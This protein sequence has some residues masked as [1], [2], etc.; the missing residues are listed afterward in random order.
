T[1]IVDMF[2]LVDIT[3]PD[4]SQLYIWVT[5][6]DGTDVVLSAYSCSGA[7][8][9]GTIF[10]DYADEYIYWGTAP[11]TGYFIPEEWLAYFNGED[12]NGDWILS[13]YDDS[14]GSAGTIDY[15]GLVIR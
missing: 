14:P 10:D 6:P 3:H 1:S 2:V 8:Y 4:L 15:F 11:Y 13:V 9:T 7:N 12:A 5:S